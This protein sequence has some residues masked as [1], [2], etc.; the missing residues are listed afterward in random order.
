M[1][2]GHYMQK[3]FKVQNT[4]KDRNSLKVALC[5]LLTFLSGTS[6]HCY[7]VLCAN[8]FY[9]SAGEVGGVPC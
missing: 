9:L 8:E 1:G 6:L 5:I 7:D 4:I 2:Y 3:S